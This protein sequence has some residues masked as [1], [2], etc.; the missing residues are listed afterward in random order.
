MD[1]KAIIAMVGVVIILVI[2]AAA[3]VVINNDD[4]VDNGTPTAL[5]D[6][7]L[8][9]YGNINGDRVIDQRDVEL[10]KQLIDDGATVDE[11]PLANA[12]NDSVIDEKDVEVV[13]KIIAGESTTIWHV[14]Y[15]DTD[16]D[17][18]MDE[19]IVSTKFPISSAIMTGS[20]N[21]FLLMT[22]LD[23]VDE[24]KGAS[25]YVS[26]VDKSLFGSTFLDESKVEK[27]G[28]SSTTI[29]LEDGKVGSSDLIAKENV[30][31]LI[32]DWNRSYITNE[33]DFEDAGID[34]V[35]VAAAS[36]EMAQIKHSALLIGL[37]FQKMDRVQEYLDLCEEVIDYVESAV[38]G[39]DTVLA[40]PSTSDGG[41]SGENSDYTRIL[42]IAGAKYAAS[43]ISAGGSNSIKISEHPEF[44]TLDCDYIVH[45]RTALNYEQENIAENYA[46]YTAY[47]S[48]W[49]NADTG[50]YMV[51][52]NVPVPLRIA[53]AAAA[54]HS[55]VI[56]LDKV[57]E[58][59]QQFVDKFYNGLEFDISSMKFFVAP[60]DY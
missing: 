60:G 55:D 1:K 9:V 33:A 32:S 59:H 22:M 51:S 5:A 21:S 54:L 46:K 27:L 3:L 38:Q 18:A 10:I 34:V 15:H 36:P 56:D 17:G 31:A 52:G 57:N 58:Y 4:D 50:Q 12:N 45:I 11:Y 37:L 35:R 16:R 48:D 42:E 20:T 29:K 2:A 44:Y 43:S 14:N 26:S 23:V 39:V 47:F 8:K 53:Y 41:I 40:V 7:E 6:A 24:I 13:E 25:Y 28:T 49:K 19:E 30:T